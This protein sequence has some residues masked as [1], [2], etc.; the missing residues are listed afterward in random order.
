MSPAYTQ[1]LQEPPS[2][3]P[4]ETK[5]LFNRC[6]QMQDRLDQTPPKEMAR[7]A[8]FDESK[9]PRPPKPDATEPLFLAERYQEL[10][11]Q[12]RSADDDML[13]YWLGQWF[14]SEGIRAPDKF[15]PPD[16]VARLVKRGG[17]SGADIRNARVVRIWLPYTEPLV[18]KTRWLRRDNARNIGKRL[19]ELGY[20]SAAIEL[21]TSKRWDSPVE[22]TCDWVASRSEGSNAEYQRETLVNSYSRY[23]ERWWSQVN[24]CSFCRAEAD[25]EFWVREE[26]IP[27]CPR[28]RPDLLPLSEDS[29]WTDRRGLRCWR[30]NLD[31]RRIPPRTSP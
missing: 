6:V 18:R 22:F 14:K 11:E 24:K 3:A 26:S 4:D 5:R 8:L 20:D 9:I 17:I 13:W 1:P 28:H 25:R 23:L 21:V 16:V 27:Y 15:V 31:I 12:L 29:A 10:V 30:Q 7:Q 2:D 19:K